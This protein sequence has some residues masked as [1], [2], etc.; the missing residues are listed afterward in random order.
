[1]APS[2]T[3]WGQLSL[4]PQCCEGGDGFLWVQRELLTQAAGIGGWH[5]LSLQLAMCPTLAALFQSFQPHF[6]PFFH[7][8]FSVQKKNSRAFLIFRCPFSCMNVKNRQSDL[9]KS[10]TFK[11]SLSV[12]ALGLPAVSNTLSLDDLGQSN[13]FLGL[14]SPSKKT[15]EWLNPIFSEI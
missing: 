3:L 15:Q 14:S 9:E 8:V 12:P 4:Y 11:K 1:M 6:N 2:C 5:P 7:R 10:S 13:T